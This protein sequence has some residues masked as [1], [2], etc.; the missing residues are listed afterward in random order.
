MARRLRV[1]V[2]MDPIENINIDA[3][4]TF[5]LILEGQARGHTLYHYDYRHMS[6][7]EGVKRPGV[8][9]RGERREDRLFARARPVTV[10]RVQGAHYTFGAIGNRRTS[11]RWTWC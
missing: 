3:D 4:S 2:Q 5:A 9:D 11:P 8:G 1:A 10:Q 7:R 6:L